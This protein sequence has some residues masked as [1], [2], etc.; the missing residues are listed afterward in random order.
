MK[1]RKPR[2]LHSLHKLARS[3]DLFWE[4]RFEVLARYNSERSRGIKHDDDWIAKM[5]ELREQY[6]DKLKR[7]YNVV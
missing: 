3:K 1:L 6:N 4:P 5:E 2:W 7:F